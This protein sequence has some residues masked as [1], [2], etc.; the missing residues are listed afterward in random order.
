MK[1]RVD[2]LRRAA[3]RIRAA[4]IAP[5]FKVVRMHPSAFAGGHDGDCHRV[6][7]RRTG[8]TRYF[9]VRVSK[10]LPQSSQW[11]CVIHEVAHA[12]TWSQRAYWRGEFHQNRWGL[13]YARVYRAAVREKASARR[14]AKRKG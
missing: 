3:R 12:L 2:L 5:P 7:D 6:K 14:A 11:D 8:K 1:R 4:R 13:A 9:R 10:T